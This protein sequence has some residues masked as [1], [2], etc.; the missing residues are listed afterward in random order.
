MRIKAGVDLRGLVPQMALAAFVVEG[1]YV[2]V[3]GEQ[4]V[5]T[6]GAD[7][8]HGEKSLHPFGRALDFRTRHVSAGLMPK[9]VAK[10]KD[11]LGGQFDVVL[12]SDHLHVEFDPK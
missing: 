9:I 8:K 12:E 7:S 6:S 10:I 1:V 5:I 4:A 2:E 11:C 3:S